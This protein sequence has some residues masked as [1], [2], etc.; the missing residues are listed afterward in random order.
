MNT[1]WLLTDWDKNSN[2][3]RGLSKNVSN[4]ISVHS[5]KRFQMRRLK[6]EKLTEDGLRMPSDGIHYF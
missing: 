3:Y 4:Q 2:L 6:C 1:L 5:A